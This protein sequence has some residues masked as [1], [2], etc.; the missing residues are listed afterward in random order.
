MRQWFLRFFQG[1]VEKQLKD[2]YMLQVK[3][4]AGL[5]LFDSAA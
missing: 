1:F 5:S 4:S 3:L 2:S